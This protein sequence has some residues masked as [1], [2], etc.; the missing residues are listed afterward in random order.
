MANW[1]EYKYSYEY[2][3]AV[4]MLRMKESL[5][6]FYYTALEIQTLFGVAR[7]NISYIRKG[8]LWKTIEEEK[9]IDLTKIPA[10][11]LP[12]H[13]TPYQLE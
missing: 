4:I 6:Q 8:R 1:K 5:E 3:K 12:L 10:K 2:L 9:N 7:K 11:I 13:C